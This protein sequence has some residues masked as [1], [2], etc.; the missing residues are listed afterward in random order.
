MLPMRALPQFATACTVVL[1]YI[2]AD[3]FGRFGLGLAHSCN[4]GATY[5]AMVWRGRAQYCERRNVNRRILPKSLP[6][7]PGERREARWWAELRGKY[8]KS[9]YQ[10]H[11]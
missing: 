3:G 2:D 8:R 4:A 10:G 6:R 1:G 9:C 11:W 7:I 5:L